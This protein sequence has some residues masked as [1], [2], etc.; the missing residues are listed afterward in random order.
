MSAAASNVAA[1]AQSP[2]NAGPIDSHETRLLASGVLGVNVW[3]RNAKRHTG[4]GPC[5]WWHG[6]ICNGELRLLV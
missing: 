2:C 6:F 5:L 1:P 3:N 4:D